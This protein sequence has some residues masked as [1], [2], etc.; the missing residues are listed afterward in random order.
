MDM[1]RRFLEYI[2][3]DAQFFGVRLHIA[4]CQGCALFHHVAEVARQRQT[5][6]FRRREARLDEQDLAAH[7]RPRQTGHDAH[8]FVGL[9]TVAAESRLT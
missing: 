8:I 3:L 1:Y 6:C 9:P 5:R 7:L 4:E 2:G